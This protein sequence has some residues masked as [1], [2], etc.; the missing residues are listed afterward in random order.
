MKNWQSNGQLSDR[1]IC[2]TIHALPKGKYRLTVYRMS[3]GENAFLF[4]ND[5]EQSLGSNGETGEDVSLDFDIKDMTDVT[6]GIKLVGFTSNNLKFDDFRL[7]YLGNSIDDPTNI[8]N[9]SKT[10]PH[11]ANLYNILG[12]RI[13]QPQKGINIINGKKFLQK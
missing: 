11:N 5:K 7:T 2:Q 6:F 4:A 13:Y 8:E 10:N 9:I 1:A 12:Q 3:A